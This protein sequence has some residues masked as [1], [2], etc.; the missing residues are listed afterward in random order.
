M[1]YSQT[2]R[3]AIFF[4]TTFVTI[5]GAITLL[6]LQDP[7]CVF[8]EAG[9]FAITLVA[10][11]IAFILAILRRLLLRLS[12]QHGAPGSRTHAAPASAAP[13][14]IHRFRPLAA[15]LPLTG[16][17][18]ADDQTSPVTVELV[19]VTPSYSGVTHG[20]PI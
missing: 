17:A 19:T 3:A 10:A 7:I 5:F 8:D 9:L 2:K 16:R 18:I 20:C 14:E 13:P 4:T 12:Q 15:A 6:S 11:T 1:R